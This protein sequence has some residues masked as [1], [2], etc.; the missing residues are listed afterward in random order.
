MGSDDEIDDVDV[1]DLE[2]LSDDE[3]TALALAA[4]PHAGFDADAVPFGVDDRRAL[5]PSW[6]M[7]MPSVSGRSRP[8]AVVIGVVVT[9]LLVLNAVGLCVTYGSIEI[10]W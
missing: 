8:R 7:P 9:S 2:P 1:D 3:L 4:D 10:A 6:Y 5:L